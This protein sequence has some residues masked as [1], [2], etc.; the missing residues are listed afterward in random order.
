MKYGRMFVDRLSVGTADGREIVLPALKALVGSVKGKK[1]L[2]L[3]CGSGRYSRIFAHLGA[4]VTGV[5]RSKFQ[6]ELAIAKEQVERLGIIYRLSDIRSSALRNATYDLVLLMFVI[7]DVHPAEMVSEFVSVASRALKLGGLLLVA[8]LHPHNIGKENAFENFTVKY[9]KGYFDNAAEACSET[10]LDDGT[11]ISFDPNYHYRLDFILNTLA[12][13][14]LC[15]QRFLEP[16]GRVPF[17][18]HMLVLARKQKTKSH[19]RRH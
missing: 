19:L 11:P 5:D 17:P 16:Q 1:V 6:I 2:D 9:G 3:G 8:D 14:G 18:T 12:E 13:E 15:L 10:W 7:L 4:N